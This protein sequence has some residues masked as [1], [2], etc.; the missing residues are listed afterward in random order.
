MDCGETLREVVRE[1]DFLQTSNF[2]IA[3]RI[4][5]VIVQLLPR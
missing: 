5:E 1:A 2:G 3:L 4:A